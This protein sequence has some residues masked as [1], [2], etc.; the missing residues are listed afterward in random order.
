M[1]SLFPWSIH[2]CEVAI[3]AAWKDGM[4]MTGPGDGRQKRTALFTGKAMVRV[5]QSFPASEPGAFDHSNSPPA[6]DSNYAL[7][8]R[9]LETAIEDDL[10]RLVTRLHGGGYHIVTLRFVEESGGAEWSK[11]QFFYVAPA[12]DNLEATAGSNEAIPFERTLSLRAGWMQ[13]SAGHTTPPSLDPVVTG[14]VEWVCGPHR[15]PC[16]SYDPDTLTWTALG[17]NSTGESTPPH[18]ALGE[19]PETEDPFLSLMLPRL[20]ED[21]QIQWEATIAFTLAGGTAFTPAS[22]HV[23][24]TNGTPEPLVML[25][26]NRMLDEPMAVF[27]FLRRVYATIGHGRICIPSVNS[28]PPPPTHE[29]AF[30]IGDVVILP[31]GAYLS[32]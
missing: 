6:A 5:E 19:M 28:T 10:S 32:T 21:Q 8:I 18:V 3:H 16:L 4:P 25:P 24:Q 30:R 23:M 17:A 26:Q 2:E 20:N 1:N 9:F 29:P 13:E 14:E 15:I 22:G 27:R 11:R 7:T 12:T 31:Q